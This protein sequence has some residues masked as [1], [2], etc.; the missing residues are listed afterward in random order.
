MGVVW[1]MLKQE[2]EVEMIN[3]PCIHEWKP[4]KICK[5]NVKM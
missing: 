5:Q 1:E 4:Q 3:V 2:V